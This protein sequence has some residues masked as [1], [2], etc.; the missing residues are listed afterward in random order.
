[1]GRPI[2]HNNVTVVQLTKRGRTVREG[3]PVSF[4]IPTVN[5]TIPEMSEDNGDLGYIAR[6]LIGKKG[7]RIDELI[8]MLKEGYRIKRVDVGKVI[9]ETVEETTNYDEYL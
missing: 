3:E 5:C 7:V 6:K 4:T 9:G 2:Y 1:M 8:G